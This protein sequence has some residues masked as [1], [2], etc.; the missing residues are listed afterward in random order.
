[1]K[2]D[3]GFEIYINIKIVE[4][5]IIK[6]YKDLKEDIESVRKEVREE[7]IEKCGKDDFKK[8]ELISETHTKLKFLTKAIMLKTITQDEI[9]FI[10]KELINLGKEIIGD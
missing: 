8:E 5:G 9:E 2:D 1:M 7:I 10:G 3:I 6:A 4:E